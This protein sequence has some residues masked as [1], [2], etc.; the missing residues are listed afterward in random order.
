MCGFDAQDGARAVTTAQ[1]HDCCHGPT[2]ERD[3]DRDAPQPV[4]VSSRACRAAAGLSGNRLAAAWLTAS[5]RRGAT[6]LSTSETDPTKVL[7]VSGLS[8]RARTTLAAACSGLMA[9]VLR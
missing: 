4:A 3:R 6:R 9:G 1:V 2:P 8:S 5:E 7:T